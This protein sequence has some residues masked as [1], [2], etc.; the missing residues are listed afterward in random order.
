MTRSRALRE[1]FRLLRRSP[2]FV[3]AVVL[4]LALALGASTAL[5]TVLRGVLLR[6]LPYAEPERLVRIEHLSARG[7]DGR[8]GLSPL[9][10]VEDLVPV[11]SLARRAAWSS[12]TA[13]L[14]GEGAPEHVRVGY[15]TASLLP[16]LGVSPALGRWFLP[17]EEQQGQHRRIVLSHGLWTRRFGGDASALGRSVLLDAE[18]FIVVGVLPPGLELPDSC[19]AWV[20]LAFEPIQRQ[21]QARNWH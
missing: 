14:G 9:N 20:P 16:V 21:P 1:A 17:D 3:A 8:M 2:G 4:P 11:R 10:L 13:A 18:P 6:P 12:G 19:D 5:F 15:A 7:E